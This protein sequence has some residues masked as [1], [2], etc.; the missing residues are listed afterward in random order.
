MKLPSSNSGQTGASLLRI[1]LLLLGVIIAAVTGYSLYIANYE[2]DPQETVIFGQSKLAAGS[3]AGLRILVRHFTS[4]KPVAGAKVELSLEKVKERI[5]LG[6]ATTDTNGSVTNVWNIPDAAPGQY[7]LRVNVSSKL[8]RDT[9]ARPVEIYRPAQ[10]LLTTDKPVYQPGQTIHLRALITNGRTLKPFAGEELTFEISDT[11]GNKVFKES[12]KASAYGIAA[13]DFELASELDLG[14]Y[15]ILVLSGTTK[16]ERTVEVKRYVLPKFRLA[17]TT[18]QS[19]YRPGQTVSGTLSAQYFFGKPVSQATVVIR[20]ETMQERPVSLST[21][22]TRTDALGNSSFSLQLPEHFTGMPQKGGQAFLELTAEVIDTG[23]QRVSTTRSLSVSA[24]DLDLTIIPEGGVIVPGLEN[25]FYILAAYPDG[26]PAECEIRAEGKTIRTDAQGIGV[27]TLKPMDKNFEF[28][29]FAQDAQGRNANKRFIATNEAALASLLLRTDKAVYQAGETAHLTVL[30]A[31]AGG[32]V[33]VD[34]IRDRQTVLTRSLP[35]QQGR[36]QLA[37]SLP[38][39]LIGQVSLNAYLISSQGEDLGCHRQIYVSP[40]SGLRIEARADQTTYRPGDT[41]R[42]EFTLR[43]AAG[44]P[45]PGAL[46]I[47][48][49]DESVFAMQE[50]QPGLLAQFLATEADLLKPRQQTRFFHSP[51]QLLT[52]GAKNDALA[53]AWF[54]AKNLS[55][56]ARSADVN[57][58]AGAYLRPGSLDY[59]KTMRG[60]P[61][62]EQLRLDE[63]WAPLIRQFEGELDLSGE[64]ASLRPRYDIREM[65]GPVKRAAAEQRRTTYF[66]QLKKTVFSIFIG[67]VIFAPVVA[68][69]L[70]ARQTPATGA[71]LAAANSE[72]LPLLQ[73]TMLTHRRLCML[74]LLPYALY[75]AGLFTLSVLFEYRGNPFP[76]LLLLECVLTAVIM[77]SVRTAWT[78]LPPPKAGENPLPHNGLLGAF[79]TIFIATRLLI[80]STDHWARNLE[81]LL[82]GLIFLS[83]LLAP[84]LLLARSATKLERLFRSKHIK[85]PSS[86]SNVMAV[87]AAI[88][89]IFVMGGMLLPSLA[90]ARTTA[91]KNSLIA[92]LKQ[93]DG[94]V[95][96]W[97]LEN[98][99]SDGIPQA[100]GPRLR[101]HFPETLY[102]QPQLITDDQGR[103]VAEVPLAD[104]ITT[105]RASLDAVNLHG[106]MGSTEMGLRVF[107]D[108][109]VDLDLPV[110]LTYGDQVTVPVVC[111]N[112]LAREQVIRLSLTDE[113]GFEVPAVSRN[114]Q[115][116]LAANEVKSVSFP[117]RAI[118]AGQQ[119][120]RITAHGTQAADA[121]ER[122]VRVLPAGTSTELLKNLV[123]KQVETLDFK[124][125]AEVIPGSAGLF[126]K[127]YPSRFSEIVEGLDSIFQAP[128]GCFEQTSS[129]TYPNVLALDYLRSI[130]RLTPETEVKA[131]KYINA[132]Y[133]RLLTFEVSGGGFEWFGKSPAHIGLTAYGVLEFHDMA[134]VHAVDPAIVTR[135]VAWLAKMQ[136]TDGSWGTG[137]GYHGWGDDTVTTTAYVAWALAESGQGTVSLERALD[138]LSANQKDLN[139]NYLKALVANAALTSGKHAAL[140]RKLLTELVKGLQV[141][142]NQALSCDSTGR[143][144][145]HSS[146]ASIRV[147]TTALV[148]LA[149]LKS[150]D[151]P[152]TLKNTLLW[153][154][155]AKNSQG[156]WPTTQATVLAM[157]ALIHGSSTTLGSGDCVV[158]I[159]L[160]GEA[161]KPVRITKATDDVMRLVSLTKQL[162]TGD[163]QLRIRLEPAGELACQIGGGYWKESLGQAS[164][165]KAEAASELQI[166]VN[167]DRTNLRL[168]DELKCKVK[169][170]NRTSSNIPM[171]IIDLGIPPGFDLDAHPFP[172]MQERGE[173]EKFEVTGNQ[174]VLYLRELK[175]AAPCT[176]TYSLRAKYPLRVS[177]PAASV[178]EYYN[179]QHRAESRPTELQ[180]T[181]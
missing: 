144:V 142:P 172:A 89:V 101:Q 166:E 12:L 90:K 21:V 19:W 113:G 7:N 130:N 50:N 92:S 15:R 56:S 62:Y 35:L 93:L 94:A 158:N 87:M 73:N 45:A 119:R 44:K 102:W 17:L 162:R 71:A 146:G 53:Q 79:A 34:V 86:F 82:L 164:I 68:L 70:S 1:I 163:N 9:I 66:R 161:M 104:S 28:A 133:Q 178:Y 26:N 151:Q 43:D 63:Q 180:V 24:S 170:H 64:P 175:T 37:L 60:T 105:W 54:S 107:Q 145:T 38:P 85:A 160:N 27:L 83:G 6:A 41:A 152:Q 167:Y 141:G 80:S 109:F 81:P 147:E 100:A 10:I 11:K 126:V 91:Q 153:L 16:T 47:S 179:P 140:G 31:D 61:T 57:Q 97:A 8:G 51:Q 74:C 95:Q 55:G 149:L 120:L 103:A 154:S 181:R 118:R 168:T 25:Q 143:S 99:R 115:V 124:L 67:I 88:S 14:R 3:P 39:D 69:I 135:T 84:W 177:A 96:Q 33:F 134:R 116:K 159:S 5:S 49:V 121:V 58:I 176:F 171:A 98:K 112:Y 111:H 136:N 131:R 117:L 155:S 108:F 23:G 129:T 40:A 29:L 125:P 174:I 32:V 114:Q 128:Y 42:L 36:G 165:Q 150:K 65:T 148:A 72:D 52:G 122:E 137:R 138:Y 110:A 48:I 173:L 18:D 77:L 59:L 78:K 2:P 169:V 156:T 30:S 22:T 46:G 123:L 127:F 20:S 139:S 157:R 132:G 4:G 106:R 76:A 75:P 13:A